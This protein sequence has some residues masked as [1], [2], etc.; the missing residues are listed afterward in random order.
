M[1]Q[2]W[3]LLTVY[4]VKSAVYANEA[5]QSIFVTYQNMRNCVVVVLSI[6]CLLFAFSWKGHDLN[7][8][9]ETSTKSK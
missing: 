1:L 8:S 5:M 6:E 4:A 2:C 9:A 3:M 7:R